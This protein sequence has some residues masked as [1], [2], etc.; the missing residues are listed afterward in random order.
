MSHPTT[1]YLTLPD[2]FGLPDYSAT[3]PVLLLC[4]LGR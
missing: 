4:S 2:R 1:E 3:E